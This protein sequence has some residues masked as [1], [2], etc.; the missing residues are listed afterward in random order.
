VAEILGI[1]LPA[2][3]VEIQ[4]YIVSPRVEAL[5]IPLAD[6]L[7]EV[8]DAVIREANRITRMKDDRVTGYREHVP[9]DDM[10]VD[11]D[12]WKAAEIRL[13]K[14]ASDAAEAM[15]N[16]AMADTRSQYVRRDTHGNVITYRNI[17]VPADLAGHWSGIEAISWTRGVES[18][19]R[20]N[21]SAVQKMRRGQ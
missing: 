5:E 15:R 16:L 8:H 18:V 19:Y 10:Y 9:E 1:E 14:V 11:R 13:Q 6:V 3:A 12:A 7:S 20:A 4:D 17:P 21:L 2:G